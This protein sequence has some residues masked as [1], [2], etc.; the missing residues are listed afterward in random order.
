M[1]PGG[2]GPRRVARVRRAGRSTVHLALAALLPPAGRPTGI[3]APRGSAPPCTRALLTIGYRRGTVARYPRQM[4]RPGPHSCPLAHRPGSTT[5][6]ARTPSRAVTTATAHADDSREPQAPTGHGTGRPARDSRHSRCH[7]PD[8]A[9][10]RVNQRLTTDSA[11]VTD[12]VGSDRQRAGPHMIRTVESSP[13]M[14]LTGHRN[15]AL[16][17]LTRRTNRG[18]VAVRRGTLRG[19]RQNRTLRARLKAAGAVGVS[20]SP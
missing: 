10:E 20:R 12:L 16:W 13:R 2:R 1:L 6:L 4:I 5:W 11:R 7:A 15:H 9:S 8:R 14:P 18:R 19:Q 3:L 17:S